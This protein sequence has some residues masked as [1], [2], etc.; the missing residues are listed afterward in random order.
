MNIIENS[1]LLL[2]D[3][4]VSYE[5][6]SFYN[7]VRVFVGDIE[8]EILQVQ[9]IKN[10]RL[11]LLVPDVFSFIDLECEDLLDLKKRVCFLVGNTHFVV[12]PGIKFNMEYFI[13][14]ARSKTSI[15]LNNSIT[16]SSPKIPPKFIKDISQNSDQIMGIVNA[17]NLQNEPKPFVFTFIDNLL[18]NLNRSKSHYEYNPFVQKFSSALHVLAGTIAY[19]YLRINLPEAFPSITTL[20]KYER[21]IDLKLNECQFR[22]DSM[23]K[24]LHSLDSRFV[25]AVSLHTYSVFIK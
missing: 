18:R 2:P 19:E 20:E 10:I 8:K 4:I 25:F 24:F 11:L 7:F 17:Q 23:D 3:D 16:I 14:L 22:F 15:Y 1:Q 6:D 5:N 9:H 21:S 13:R 12:K